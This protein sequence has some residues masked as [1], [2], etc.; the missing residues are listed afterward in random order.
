MM[1]E[2]EVQD[3]LDLERELESDFENNWA[4]PLANAE[5]VDAM[6]KQL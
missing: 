4:Q 3:S 2:Q 1:S 6:H 5:V